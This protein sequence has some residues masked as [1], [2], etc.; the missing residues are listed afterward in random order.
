MKALMHAPK[1]TLKQFKIIDKIHFKKIQIYD[2]FSHLQ[3]YYAQND[4][5]G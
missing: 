4:K 5:Q 2:S 1:M 3:K